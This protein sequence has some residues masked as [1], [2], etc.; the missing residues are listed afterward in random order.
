MPFMIEPMA[1]SRIPKCSTRP[2]LLPLHELV[3]HCSGVKLGWPSG[4]VLLDSARSAE[5]PQSSGRTG[6][7]ALRSAPDALRV[8]TPLS[9]AGEDGRAAGPPG[10]GGGGGVP[11]DSALCSGWGG[12]P[13]GDRPAPAAPAGL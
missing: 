10:G 8:A 3:C 9:S 2:Y 4:V 1:C 13:A 11:A 12:G 6:A 5:P 7:I